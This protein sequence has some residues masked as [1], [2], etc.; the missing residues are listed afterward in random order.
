M[1]EIDL[2]EMFDYFRGKVIWILVAC[3]FAVIVQI[4]RF[5]CV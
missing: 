4:L 2:K 3:I 1:E 5:I